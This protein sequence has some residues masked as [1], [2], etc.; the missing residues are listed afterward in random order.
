MEI[1]EKIP[2]DKLLA[3]SKEHLFYEIDMLYGVSRTLINGMEDRYIYNAL[4]ESFIIHASVILDFFYEPQMNADDA[5]AVHY[6]ADIKKWKTILPPQS[7]GFKRFQRKRN[8]E[9]VHL[10]YRRLEVQPEE[11]KWAVRRTTKQ[12]KKIVNLFLENAIKES[13][14]PR[15]WEF[16]TGKNSDKSI[17]HNEIAP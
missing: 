16:Y 13:I 11:K 4:L 5:K 3:F 14:S 17:Q 10:S 8:K 6:M 9:L 1:L 12:I 15:L 7:E 2:S